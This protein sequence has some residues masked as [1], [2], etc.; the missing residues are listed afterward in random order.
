MKLSVIIPVYNEQA[1]IAALIEKVRAVKLKNITKE[2]IVVDDGSTDDSRQQINAKLQKIPNLKVLSLPIN[3]GKGAAIRLGLKQSTGDIVIIQDADLELDPQEFHLLLEPIL[4]N[5]AKIVYGSRI[6]NSQTKIPFK[7]WLATKI[8][9]TLTGLLF[10]HW[11]SDINTAYKAF[12]KEVLTK[13]NL[14]SVQFEFDAEFTVKA[15]KLG[16]KIAE[17]PVSFHPRTRLQGKKIRFRDGLDL[18]FT[19]IKY[20]LVND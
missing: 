8:T 12:T 2:I 18:V 1:T 3:L 4:S 9:S 17:V 15:L 6:L 13:I 5:Q 16:F 7:S 11:V 10:G 20:R 19:I 14:R